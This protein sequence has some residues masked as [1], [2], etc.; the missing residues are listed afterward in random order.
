[1][2]HGL[3]SLFSSERL[4]DLRLLCHGVDPAEVEVVP[5]HVEMFLDRSTL[6]K[7]MLEENR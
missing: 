2:S 6:I 7:T 4:C 5:A 1:M 3:R